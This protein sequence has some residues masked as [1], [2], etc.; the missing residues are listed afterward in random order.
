MV[1]PVIEAAAV[2]LGPILARVGVALLGGA[3]VAGT[4]SLSGDTPK[5]D[6]KATPD[7]RAL[8]RTGEKCKQC[9]PEQTGIPVRR[10]YRMNREPRE[11]QGRVTGRPYS[12]EEG[13]SEEWSWLGLDYD[14]FQTSECLLQEAKGNFDQFF[15]RKTRRPM[16]WFSGFR[17]IDLQIEARANIVRANPPTK[18]RY[19]FQTPLTASYFRERL[20]RNGITYVV[21]G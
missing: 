10:Y 14:G 1:F 21:T 18:L 12:I 2:E 7:V 13:W 3:T 20:A 17:K 11:Y 15:S 4:A 9:P 6:S 19:Y 5:E 8:P 16:K